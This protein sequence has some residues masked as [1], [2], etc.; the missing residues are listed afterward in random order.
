M[1]IL[2]DPN[3][4]GKCH[5]SVHQA[6]TIDLEVVRPCRN[7]VLGANIVQVGVELSKSGT[8]YLVIDILFESSFNDEG[9]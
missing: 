8:V 1:S 5:Y 4:E 9:P 2:E 6:K 7:R 3:R